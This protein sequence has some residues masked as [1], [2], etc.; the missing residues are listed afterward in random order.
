MMSP[1]VSC[2]F[3]RLFRAFRRLIAAAEIRWFLANWLGF[4]VNFAA[5][6]L[7]LMI[8]GGRGLA[9]AAD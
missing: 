8:F 5:G 2:L 1:P 3:N 9:R 4:V 7:F 6:L